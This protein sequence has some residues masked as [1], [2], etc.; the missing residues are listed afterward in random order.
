MYLFSATRLRVLDWFSFKPCVL[1][2]VSQV[3]PLWL[4]C[5]GDEFVVSIYCVGDVCLI[6]GDLLRKF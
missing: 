6:D 1:L 4:V 5:V 2:T 3:E